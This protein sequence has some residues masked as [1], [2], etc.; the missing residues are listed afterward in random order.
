MSKRYK[1]VQHR[2]IKCTW[3]LDSW[4]DT[5]PCSYQVKVRSKFHQGVFLIYLIIITKSLVIYSCWQVCGSRHVLIFL[6]EEGVKNVQLLWK[7]FGNKI[8][9]WLFPFYPVIGILYINLYEMLESS[10]SHGKV[11]CISTIQQWDL[12]AKKKESKGPCA[13]WGTEVIKYCKSCAYFIAVW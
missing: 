9:R 13:L 3:S 5:Q 2:K 10:C 12:S 4:E 1:H 8:N 7:E 6:R 11:P